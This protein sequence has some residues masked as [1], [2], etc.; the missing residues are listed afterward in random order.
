MVP[1]PRHMARKTSARIATAAAALALLITPAAASACENGGAGP[2]EISID[3]A[4]EALICLV[5]ERRK[6]QGV[7]RLH[8]DSRLESAAQA[9]SDSMANENYFSH[10]SPNGASPLTRI[11]NSG[12]L[13]GARSW[14][15]G[16]NIRWG[17]GGRSTPRSA[18][19]AWMSSAGH[20]R[21]MLTRSYRDIGIG[22]TIGSPYGG[23]EDGMIFTADFGYR[24]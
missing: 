21:A 23:G 13:A 11:Q 6:K 5:N 2:G 14:G 7:R 24:H 8:N 12:Y 15:I 3:E 1:I 19:K 10:N 9:H 20:R 16:E 22:A 18:V 17:A 4:R